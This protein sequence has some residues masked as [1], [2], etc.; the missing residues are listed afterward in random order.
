MNKKLL[1]TALSLIAVAVVVAVSDQLFNGRDSRLGQPLA[2]M[3]DLIGMDSV[4]FAQKDKELVLVKDKDSVW[5]LGSET[6]FPA[7]ASKVSRLVDDLTRNEVQM[8]VSS[9]KEPASEFGLSEPT[10]ITLRKG[11]SDLVRIRIGGRRDRGGQYI[12][13]A[14]DPKVYL[15]SLSL[16]ARPEESNWELKRLLNIPASQIKKITFNPARGSNKKPVTLARE[17][18]EDPMKIEKPSTTLKEAA[19]IRSHESILTSLDFIEKTAADNQ[20]AKK[21]LAKPS[22]VLVTLFDGREFN[23]DVGS[24]GTSPKKYFMLITAK[25]GENTAASDAEEI[26]WINK[27]MKDHA[28]EVSASVAERFE[29]TFRGHPPG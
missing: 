19:N 26:D 3:T 5:R 2:K 8:L 13:F 17:K 6:G 12:S 4:R 20:D 25:K 10:E 21:A 11:T 28:I 18:T 24:T 27:V 23:I 16:E 15:I 29:K 14:N 22:K 1:I 9:A 7:D